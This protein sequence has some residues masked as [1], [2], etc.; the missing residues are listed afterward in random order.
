MFPG[1]GNL[2]HTHRH[3]IRRNGQLRP[4]RLDERSYLFLNQC[5][6]FLMQLGIILEHLSDRLHHGRRVHQLLD[7]LQSIL[8]DI[9][10]LL[11]LRTRNRFDAAHA[12]RYGT[13]GKNPEITDITGSRSV[14]SAAQFY[15]I[16]ET[17]RTYHPRR[18]S[19]R[20]ASSPPAF[21]PR[22]SYCSCSLRADSWHEFIAFTIRSTSRICSGVTFWKCE[23][24][25][26]R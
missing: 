25:N 12:G 24:S 23:K 1:K 4:H 6:Q 3:F 13:F 7:T 22:Q 17:Y 21:S 2:R 9:H 15:R 10:E 11:R 18:T 20:R 14:R 16:A 19:H 8:H 26:R 5:L